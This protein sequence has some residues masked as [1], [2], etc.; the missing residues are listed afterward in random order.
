MSRNTKIVE[1]AA[2]SLAFYCGCCPFEITLPILF[3]IGRIDYTLRRQP[4]FLTMELIQLISAMT[5]FVTISFIYYPIVTVTFLT[6]SSTMTYFALLDAIKLWVQGFFSGR[7]L[8]FIALATVGIDSL[9]QMFL[10]VTL[11][12]LFLIYYPENNLQK[13]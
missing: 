10:Y 11:H 1:T 5:I 13:S 4:N 9:I 3:N 12:T 7:F 6:I 8:I 2:P